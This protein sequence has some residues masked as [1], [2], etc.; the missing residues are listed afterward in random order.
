MPV[1]T[2]L[3]VHQRNKDR[4]KLFLDDAFAMDL[5]S[6]QAS[7][8]APGQSLTQAEVDALSEAKALQSAYDRALRFLSY[9]PR[10]ADEVRRHLERNAVAKVVVAV[11]IE[12]LNERGYLDDLAFAQFWLENRNRFKPIAPRA[13]RYELRQKGVDDAIVESVLSEVDV[14]EAAYRAAQ[15]RVTRYRGSTRQVFRSKLYG[16]L[17]RRGFDSEAIY[18]VVGRLQN[19]LERSEDGYFER[20]ADD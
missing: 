11:V 16:L 7:Q 19:E 8:L 10:S 3:E 14:E 4:V 9:R 15:S 2:A 12:R 13:L 5:S 1:I 20:D 17:R 6:L 18:A